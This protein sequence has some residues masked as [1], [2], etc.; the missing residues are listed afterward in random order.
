MYRLLKLITFL[1]QQLC[2]DTGGFKAYSA[3]CARSAQFVTVA[4][5]AIQEKVAQACGPTA[6]RANVKR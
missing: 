6:E 1:L 4:A 3:T 5:A 2:F